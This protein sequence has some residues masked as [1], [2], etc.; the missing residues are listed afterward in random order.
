M[1]ATFAGKSGT[2]PDNEFGTDGKVE[3]MERNIN[4]LKTD[5]VCFLK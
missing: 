2:Q 4:M 3:N 1:V 5:H